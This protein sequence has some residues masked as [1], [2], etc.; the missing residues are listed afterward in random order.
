MCLKC[1]FEFKYLDTFD[2][3]FW[4]S[5][6]YV[7]LWT[8]IKLVSFWTSLNKNHRFLSWFS[9]TSH[10]FFFSS[11]LKCK[12]SI[13][14][15]NAA[16]VPG[17]SDCPFLSGSYCI[18]G[19]GL[20][21]TSVKGAEVRILKNGKV[22]G[23]NLNEEKEFLFPLGGSWAPS[24][25]VSVHLFSPGLISGFISICFYQTDRSALRRCDLGIFI[26]FPL[27]VLLAAFA[28]A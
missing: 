16:R 17:R 20:G 19:G 24:G 25:S 14:S 21:F 7:W 13:S 12:T 22:C 9:Q 4:G 18:G 26:R 1:Y 28:C 8:L 5:E 23:I 2:V 10:L 6:I 15:F 11:F 27:H 3:V